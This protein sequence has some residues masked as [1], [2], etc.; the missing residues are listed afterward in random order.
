L[1]GKY[2]HLPEAAFYMVGPIEEVE[3]K[4]AKMARELSGGKDESK[5]KDKKQQVGSKKIATP[6]DVYQN[7]INWMNKVKDTPAQK[8]KNWDEWKA[9]LDKNL[10]QHKAVLGKA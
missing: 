5:D 9:A 6:D 3:A 1:G 10:E 2:D 4:A 8:G 7:A